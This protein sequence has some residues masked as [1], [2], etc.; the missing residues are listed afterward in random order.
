VL[1]F[2]KKGW[3]VIL[4]VLGGGWAAVRRVLRGRQAA[5]P[6]AAERTDT[7]ESGGGAA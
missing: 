1:L 3:I 5:A 6:V 4:A 7:P 2:L